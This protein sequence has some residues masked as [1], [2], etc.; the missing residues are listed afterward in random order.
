MTEA[1]RQRVE[2]DRQLAQY[3][4]DRVIELKRQ[5]EE[6]RRMAREANA[7]L[8]RLPIAAPYRALSSRHKL[9]LLEALLRESVEP[10]EP[11]KPRKPGPVPG[12]RRSLAPSKPYLAITPSTPR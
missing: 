5:R 8:H 9:A 4:A 2:R 10:P 7:E 12:A 6:G 1:L 11:S 3:I